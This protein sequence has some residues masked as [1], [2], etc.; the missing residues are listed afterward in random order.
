MI[1]LVENI[2][3]DCVIF[4]FEDDK[5]KVLL[6]K[7]NIDPRKGWMALPG[8]F[9]RINEDLSTA[10]RRILWDLTGIRDLYME[11]IHTFGNV[12]RY[13]NRR[14]ITVAYYALIN[15]N[16]Y[17]LTPGNE[18]MDARWMDVKNLPELPF[19]HHEI[20]N[21]AL[22]KLRRRVRHEPV[23]FNLLPNKFTLSQL[24]SLY[25]A[26][27]DTKFDKRNFRRKIHRMKFLVDLGEKQQNVAHRAAKLYSFDEEKYKRLK[28][29]GFNFDL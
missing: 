25:E 9:I 12:D 20:F 13:P 1:E 21:F 11:Q 5:L 19:D 15:I 4:G 8:G 10:S 28:E 14:V 17:Q 7:R 16:N 3:I 18:A 23:G 2:S 6:I 26:I 27:L 24:Q 22:Q 29:K